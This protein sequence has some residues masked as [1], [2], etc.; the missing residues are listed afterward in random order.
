M[1]LLPCSVKPFRL[2][3]IINMASLVTMFAMN[4]IIPIFMQSVLGVS[5]FSASLTLFP[6][7]ALCCILSPL[8]GRIYDKRGAR[9]LL[10]LGFALIAIFA[11]A[12]SLF[13]GGG[14]IRAHWLGAGSTDRTVFKGIKRG[15]PSPKDV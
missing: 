12:L 5:S 1:E 8:A 3:V 14:C 10:P 11:V 15:A 7:I 2:G 6:A 9:I 13:I 4:I